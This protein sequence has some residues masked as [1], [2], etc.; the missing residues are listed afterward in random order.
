MLSCI[1]LRDLFISSL[2][3]SI[4]FI[5]DFKVFF[6]RFS[7]VELFR[8]CCD[9]I[10]GLQWK[11]IALAVID[12]V[13]RRLGVILGLGTDFWVCLCWVGGFP[14]NVVVVCCHFPGLLGWCVHK[15]C[16]LVFGARMQG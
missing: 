3:T 2:S 5:I 10:A 15:E 1:S 12:C 7:Y 13:L 11:H 9:R 8:A 16:L 6:L 4:L 14:E